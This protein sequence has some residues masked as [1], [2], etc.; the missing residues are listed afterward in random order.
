MNFGKKFEPITDKNIET[1]FERFYAL[2][3]QNIDIYASLKKS[4]KSKSIFK[5]NLASPKD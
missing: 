3:T 2:I 1:V 5:T 4:A